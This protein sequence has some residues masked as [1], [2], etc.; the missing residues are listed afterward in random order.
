MY[1]VHLE[2]CVCVCVC[3]HVLCTFVRVCV[4]LSLL[5]DFRNKGNLKSRFHDAVCHLKNSLFTA[6]S[7]SRNCNQ[8]RSFDLFYNNNVSVAKINQ[9]C[10]EC[11]YPPFA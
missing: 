3:K 6:K 8:F 2:G 10:V 11:L 7:N 4:L 1:Y 9:N 5:D